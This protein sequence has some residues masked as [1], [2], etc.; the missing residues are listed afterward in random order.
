M[1]LRLKLLA[2]IGALIF[3]GASITG[4]YLKGRMDENKIQANESLRT[5]QK[6]VEKDATIDREVHRMD[7]P[8]LDNALR[9]WLQ[10]Y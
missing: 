9:N 3:Y 4:A 7:E 2:I 1:K 10:Q 5:Y 8:A 6:G